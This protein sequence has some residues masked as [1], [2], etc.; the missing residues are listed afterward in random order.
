MFLHILWCITIFLC[1][2]YSFFKYKQIVIIKKYTAIDI[3][4]ILT[5]FMDKSYDTIYNTDLIHYIVN[6]DKPNSQQQETIERNYIK[7]CFMYMGKANKQLFVD[8]FGD[9]ETLII[10]IICYMRKKYNDDGLSKIIDQ[11]TKQIS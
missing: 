10:N 1:V 3:M 4:N 9:E 6:N 5:V 11:Q 2:F 8:F 7:T